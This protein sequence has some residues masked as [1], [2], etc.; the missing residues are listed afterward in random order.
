MCPLAGFKHL[1]KFGE[2]RQITAVVYA[3]CFKLSS[4]YNVKESGKV[5]HT[6]NNG[7]TPKFNHFMRIVLWGSSFQVWSTSIN[8]FVS[9]LAQR[10]TNRQ[11]DRQKDTETQ[12]DQNTCSTRG[13]QVNILKQVWVD[14]IV[15]NSD[16]VLVVHSNYGT[17]TKQKY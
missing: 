16:V 7:S 1:I 17:F 2:N 14:S 6:S 8:A 15:T 3:K 13:T 4:S 10:H 11:T 9:Y 5:I 12:K